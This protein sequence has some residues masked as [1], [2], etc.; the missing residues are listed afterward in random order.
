MFV[1]GRHS[2][3]PTVAEGLLPVYPPLGSTVPLL[4]SWS[5]GLLI[6]T[7]RTCLKS[8]PIVNMSACG[9]RLMRKKGIINSCKRNID[10]LF[11]KNNCFHWISKIAVKDGSYWH[12]NSASRWLKSTF[13]SCFSILYIYIHTSVYFS[14]V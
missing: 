5:F 12:L 9:L 4:P 11:K 7:P 3:V 14:D 10:T 6:R 1:V 2:V 8:A 13:L